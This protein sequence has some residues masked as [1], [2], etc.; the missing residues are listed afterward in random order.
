MPPDMPEGPLLDDLSAAELFKGLADPRTHQAISAAPVQQAINAAPP[1]EVPS[2]E[3][4]MIRMPGG[5]APLYATE[6]SPV[7]GRAERA[8]PFLSYEQAV[9]TIEFANEARRRAKE[10]EVRD[11]I[12]RKIVEQ[13]AGQPSGDLR[14]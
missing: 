3:L 9:R 12:R 14:F 10:M 1:A 7:I 4:R 11:M 5:G 13:L 2:A 8:E 6:G